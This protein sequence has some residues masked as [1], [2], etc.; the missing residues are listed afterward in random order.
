MKK[1]IVKIGALRNLRQISV[2]D[3]SKIY[4]FKK[5]TTPKLPKFG[6]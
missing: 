6:E 3:L 1:V 4:Y 5:K 2:D